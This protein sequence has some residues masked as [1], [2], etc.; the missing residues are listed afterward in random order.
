MTRCGR[1]SPKP[2]RRG[3]RSGSISARR[4]SGRHEHFP[5]SSRD[6]ATHRHLSA[7]LGLPADRRARQRSDVARLPHRSVELRAGGFLDAWS[8]AQGWRT[9]LAPLRRAG[10]RLGPI[11]PDMA[12][13]NRARSRHAGLLRHP[14][15][16]RLAAAAPADR[17]PAPFSVVSTGTWVIAMAVGGAA[18][19]LDPARDTLVNVNALGDPVPS[20]RFMGGREFATLVGE[21]VSTTGRASDPARAGR[22][23]PAA[24][25]G[26]AGLRA[27][28]EAQ[29]R[30]IGGEPTGDARHVAASFYLAMMTATAWTSSAP[31][32]RRSSKVRSRPIG[33]SPTCLRPRPRG[34]SSRRAPARP[35]PASAPRCWRQARARR[36]A[37]SVPT[38]PRSHR[39][40]VPNGK[41]TRR[42]GAPRLPLSVSRCR[43]SRPAPAAGSSR[44]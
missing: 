18:V 39:R 11:L 1:P 6:V 44:S 4:S 2:A 19:E 9:L 38:A 7:I 32:G 3:C 5:R 27:V 36:R 16:Q 20:A 13:A 41:P 15:F 17:A 40:R 33:R 23:R 14:R 35:A 43:R 28:P 37:P 22:R 21:G 10:D 26:A 29:G 31:T 8:T 42:A 34:R 30:W 12:A 24:A 25:I